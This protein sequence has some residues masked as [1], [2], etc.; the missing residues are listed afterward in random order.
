MR[1]PK[2]SA[3]AFL[4]VIPE[5]NLLSFSGLSDLLYCSSTTFVFS[6]FRQARIYNDTVTSEDM[7]KNEILI[8]LSESEKTKFGKEDFDTQSTAQKVFS[9]IWAL[10]SQVYNG[11]F[12]QYFQN[13]SSETAGFVVEALERL[14]ASNTADICRRAIAAAFPE[15]LPSDPE[16]ISSAASD[17]SIEIQDSLDLLDNEFFKQP[18]DLT[19][20]L[21]AFVSEHPAEFGKLP[22]PDDEQSRAPMSRF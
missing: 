5:G 8:S 13:L 3:F 17:F 19:Q 9:S 15:G 6:M 22:K 7:D 21:F 1:T 2:E 4:S 14:G 18:N 11:G 16:V 20:L 10:E 12:S